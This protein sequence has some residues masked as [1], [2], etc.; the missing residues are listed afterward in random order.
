HQIVPADEL[1]RLD[2]QTLFADLRAGSPDGPLVTERAA[3]AMVCRLLMRQHKTLAG[4]TGGPVE[5]VQAHIDAGLSGTLALEQLAEVAGMSL[6]HFCR[7]FRDN[8]GVTPHQYIL[9][10]R[11]AQAKRLLW[12]N[13]G[14][15]MLEIALACGFASSSHF[16]TQFK[17]HVGQTPLQWQRSH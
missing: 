11:M 9:A 4:T 2:A 13:S 5:K 7:V 1:L 17:R 12:T 14:L 16:S 3:M 8:L 15:S 6:F 10:R